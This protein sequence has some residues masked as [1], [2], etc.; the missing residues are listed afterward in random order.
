MEYEVAMS[1][2]QIL[3]SNHKAWVKTSVV[4][5]ICQECQFISLSK[6]DLKHIYYL[7]LVL[8]HLIVVTMLAG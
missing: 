5:K 6:N 2:T 3:V 4:I 1:S 8:L 7:Y